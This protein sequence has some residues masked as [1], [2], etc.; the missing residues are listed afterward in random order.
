VTLAAAV[1]VRRRPSG[2]AT[3]KKDKATKP[4]NVNRPHKDSQN[5]NRSQIGSRFNFAVGI[6]LQSRIK[7][8]DV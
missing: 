6:R 8:Q 5:D 3:L 4:T 1:A 7:N 2:W